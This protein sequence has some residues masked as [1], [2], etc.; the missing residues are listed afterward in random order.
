ML[1]LLCELT[2]GILIESA[3]VEN[4][5]YDCDSTMLEKLFVIVLRPSHI[6]GYIRTGEKLNIKIMSQ[7]SFPRKG[8]Q[9]KQIWNCAIYLLYEHK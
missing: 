4:W 5:K 2:N 6:Y 3:M 8:C 7:E 1:F 9:S